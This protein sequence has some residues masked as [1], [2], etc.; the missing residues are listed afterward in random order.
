M[1]WEGVYRD[2]KAHWLRW[3][4]ARGRPIS[5]GEERT[6]RAAERTRRERARRK[7]LEG[8]LRQRAIEP[9]A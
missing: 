2:L 9:E 5:T 1:R 6:D 4:D 8:Q 3:C 7:K